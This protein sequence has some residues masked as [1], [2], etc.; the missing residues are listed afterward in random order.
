[1]SK[2]KTIGILGMPDNAG[3]KDFTEYLLLRGITIDFIVY[4]TPSF[5]QNLHRVRRKLTGDGILATVERIW[6]ALVRSRASHQSKS[7]L[8]D[9][10]KF[11]VDNHN[12]QHCQRIL[13]ENE[14]DILLLMTDCIISSAILKIP[15]LATL[16]SHPGWIPKYRGLDALFYQLMDGIFPAASVHLVDEGVDTGPLLERRYLELDPTIGLQD[17]LMQTEKLQWELMADAI[18]KLSLA[19]PKTID[20][21]SEWSSMYRGSV[22]KVK[23]LLDRHLKSGLIKFSKL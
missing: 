12:N 7:R 18:E 8:D 17:I 15:K 13:E 10:K 3:T 19:G 4:W 21:S 2:G 11:Y 14:V 16:N 6:F 9:I 20:A 22:P 23:R 1:M 5:K